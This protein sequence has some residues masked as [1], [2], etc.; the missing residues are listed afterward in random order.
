MSILGLYLSKFRPNDPHL[1]ETSQDCLDYCLTLRR[2]H[3]E[4]PPLTKDSGHKGVSWNKIRN[5]WHSR[6]CLEGQNK[7]L[8]YFDAK[9]EAHA[10]YICAAKKMHGPFYNYEEKL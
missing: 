3:D 7:H 8:G 2:P 4:Q 9:E 6:I 5:K 10:A 1:N